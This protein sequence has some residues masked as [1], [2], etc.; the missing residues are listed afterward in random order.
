MISLLTKKSFICCCGN[1]LLRKTLFTEEFLGISLLKERR[2]IVINQ[3]KDQGI[4]PKDFR[5]KLLGS[6]QSIVKADEHSPNVILTEDLS[7]L[8]LTSKS[9]N[10]LQESSD[11]F[12]QYINSLSNDELS[13]VKRR[14]FIGLMR[15]L[16]QLCHVHSHMKPLVDLLKVKYVYSQKSNYR[17][18][19]F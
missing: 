19:F 7:N 6:T 5:E 12:Q 10:T 8:I 9:F 18:S 15:D 14:K 2:G 17:K 4:K 1:S 16:A 13:G 3:L 11:F